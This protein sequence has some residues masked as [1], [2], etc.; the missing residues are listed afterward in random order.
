MTEHDTILDEEH[1][2]SAPARDV[3]VIEIVHDRGIAVRN[4]LER[5]LGA[6]QALGAHLV[7]ATTDASVAIAHAPAGVIDEIRGGATLPAAL[8]HTRS[9]VG[10]VVN[11]TGTRVRAAIGEYVGHQATLP[12]AFVAGAS[13]VAETVLR[14]Q[15]NVAATAIDSAFTVAATATRGGNLRDAVDRERRDLAAQVDAAR[16]DVAASWERAAEEIRAAVE[17]YVEDDA[18]YL[19][20]FSD[21]G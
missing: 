8:A 5:Q 4:L 1:T 2:D 10:G 14:A 21:E 16:A 6:G 9:E 19:E 11:R 20:P 18:E 13:D 17:D 7:G 3:E 12:N 15:G